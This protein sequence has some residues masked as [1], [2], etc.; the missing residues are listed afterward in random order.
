MADMH[1]TDA[2]RPPSVVRD[3]DDTGVSTSGTKEGGRVIRL[4]SGRAN[5]KTLFTGLI[6]PSFLLLDGQGHLYVSNAGDLGTRAAMSCSRTRSQTGAA[7]PSLRAVALL[8]GPGCARLRWGPQTARS[9]AITVPFGLALFGSW[10]FV[11]DEYAHV[12]YRVDLGTGASTAM[13][14][15][16]TRARRRTRAQGTAAQRPAQGCRTHR[17]SPSTGS[18]TSTSSKYASLTPSS[19]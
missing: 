13:Q 5:P 17:A 1:G 2:L 9:V 6:D 16:A 19:H 8:Q 15:R 12:V 10:L 7:A 14:G 3:A 11:A 18:P 4:G